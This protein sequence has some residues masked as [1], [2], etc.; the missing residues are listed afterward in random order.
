V[1]LGT[2]AA[3]FNSVGYTLVRYRNC[4]PAFIFRNVP[5]KLEQALRSL[6]PEFHGIVMRITYI[7]R[8]IR[9]LSV[10]M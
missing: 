6:C 4:A 9:V 8:L 1:G 7:Y 3:C 10:Q 2:V 5:A